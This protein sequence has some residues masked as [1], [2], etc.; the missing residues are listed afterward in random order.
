ML[1][2]YHYW[3]IICVLSELPQSYKLNLQTIISL[4]FGHVLFESLK[5]R[6][7]SMPKPL[8]DLYG[9]S[10]AKHLIVAKNPQIFSAIS[11]LEY[12]YLFLLISTIR[13][14]GL[15]YSIQKWWFHWIY[16]APII[17]WH[18]TPI[19]IALRVISFCL[20]TALDLSINY[21]HSDAF[22]TQ[23]SNTSEIIILICSFPQQFF[24]YFSWNYYECIQPKPYLYKLLY[25]I[26]FIMY[27][28]KNLKQ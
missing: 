10:F 5:D 11:E 23:F 3:D 2:I 17:C 20:L 6:Y 18:D 25:G 24:C 8:Q 22:Q 13:L 21:V 9:I 7:S 26:H 16:M 27:W 19:K 12:S 1:L 15:Y 14:I 28:N 4:L